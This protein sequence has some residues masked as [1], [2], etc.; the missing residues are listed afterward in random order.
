[1]SHIAVL[2]GCGQCRKDRSGLSVG[3]KNLNDL[4]RNDILDIL[5]AVAEIL[6]GI[7]V[8]GMSFHVLADTGCHAKAKVGVDIDLAD[9]A[10]SCQ[11]KLILRN[12]DR[13]LKSAAVAVDDLDI[14]LRN[15]GRSVK[16]DRESGKSSCY[17]CQDVQA[18]LGIC[19]G[20]ELVS[21]VACADG[22]SQGIN[23]C[24]LNELFD[25]IGICEHSLVSINADRILDACEGSELS[26][27]NCAVCMSILG[28]LLGL[29]D[30]VL[31]I[32]AGIVD[33][34]AEA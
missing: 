18:K 6:S 1:M 33:H 26:L 5:A 22:D 16:N 19:A 29:C 34:P 21:A 4:V 28:D 3:T 7:K 17:F 31:E 10:L 20:F 12:T 14:F 15:G 11:T 30:V 9:C 2:F 13:I 27:N 23:A 24:S 8:I 32:V 25:L